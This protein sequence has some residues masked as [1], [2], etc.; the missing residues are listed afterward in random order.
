MGRE[1]RG[2]GPAQGLEAVPASLHPRH[3]LAPQGGREERGGGVLLLADREQGLGVDARGPRRIHGWEDA[4]QAQGRIEQ[5]EGR[6]PAQVPLPGLEAQRGAQRPHLGIEHAVGEVHALGRPGRAR[7]EEDG[8]GVAGRRGEG[9]VVRVRAPLEDLQRAGAEGEAWADSDRELHEARRP[10]RAR[11][12]RALR[13]PMRT[14]GR[15]RSIAPSRRSRPMPGSASTG[16]APMRSRPHTRAIRSSPGGTKTATRS[17]DRTPASA[18]P[19]AMRAVRA[20]SSAKV[21]L[22]RPGPLRST[23]AS[24]SPARVAWPSRCSHVDLLRERAEGRKGSSGRRPK[25]SVLRGA[26]VEHL[27]LATEMSSCGRTSAC[28]RASRAGSAA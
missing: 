11:A 13:I 24:C 15:V 8:C 14:R 5:R 10:K 3:E 22:R 1:A 25:G 27:G 26:G 19:E 16:T 12:A 4:G 17:P 7:G 6:Q 18:S 20:L 21:Q 23:M 2:D 9:G 28:A